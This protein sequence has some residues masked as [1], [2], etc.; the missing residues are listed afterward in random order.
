M[1]GPLF[2]GIG[3][4]T[5]YRHSGSQIASIAVKTNVYL[6]PDLARRWAWDRFAVSII[7]GS[8]VRGERRATAVMNAIVSE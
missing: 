4:M 2:L 1:E 5:V 3:K 7:G 6:P 8:E